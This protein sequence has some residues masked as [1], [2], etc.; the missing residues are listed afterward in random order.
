VNWVSRVQSAALTKPKDSRQ[1]ESN[2]FGDPIRPVVEIDETDRR[3]LK[4]LSED[5]RLSSRALAREIG[6]SPGT[7]SERITRLEHEG[8]LLGYRAQIDQ[9]VLGVGMVAIVGLRTTQAA[10]QDAI[11][12]LAEIDEV[13]K[14]YVVTGAWDLMVVIRVRDH[15]HLSEVLFDRIWRTAGFQQSETMIVMHERRGAGRIPE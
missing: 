10:L 12:T 11:A 1:A 6:M 9:S 3:I 14:V 7:I 4:L 8:V 5:A 15:N 13:D 2:R